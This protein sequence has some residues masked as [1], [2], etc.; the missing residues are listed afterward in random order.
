MAL[1]AD[2]RWDA[3]IGITDALK[4]VKL[5]ISA[6]RFGDYQHSY[7]RFGGSLDQYNA[8]CSRIADQLRQAGHYRTAYTGLPLSDT[9][10]NIKETVTAQLEGIRSTGLTALDNALMRLEEEMR[11]QGLA[12]PEYWITR[13]YSCEY[14]CWKW[15]DYR[16]DYFYWN[17]Q[18]YFEYYKGG[19]VNQDGTPYVWRDRTK[20]GKQRE[21]KWRRRRKQRHCS[22]KFGGVIVR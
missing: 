8:R 22:W 1:C 2:S 20:P 5:C 14:V 9:I 3:G 15:D 7:P 21:R 4:L 10:M 17:T 11:I 6:M 19:K 18:G 13:K 12:M 16:K